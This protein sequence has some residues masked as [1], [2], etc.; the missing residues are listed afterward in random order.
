[1]AEFR[2]SPGDAHSFDPLHRLLEQQ[3]YRL[4]YWR[5]AS[6]EINYRRFFDINDL[7]GLRT[8][9]PRVFEATH[10]RIFRWIAEGGVTGLRIDHPDGL[11]DP[12]GYLRRLQ[13]R[14]F[15]H[16]CHERHANSSDQPMDWPVIGRLIRDRYR[17]EIDR[18]AASPLA[19]RFPIVVEKILTRDE[20]IPRDWPIDGTVGY[21]FLNALNGLFVDPEGVGLD[22]RDLPGFHG[23]DREP[24]RGP[25]RRQKARHA[26]EPGERAEHARPPARPNRRA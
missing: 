12:A 3:V 7:A 6:E 23:R 1:M 8:E 14:L 2:G 19:R 13:E 17:A 25:L 18:D 15:L 10:A 21:E 11:A 5:V 20:P 16:A 22:P 24:P 9:D 26:I 4:S